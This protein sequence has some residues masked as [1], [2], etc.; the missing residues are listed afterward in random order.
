MDHEC[1]NVVHRLSLW[2]HQRVTARAY[3]L[4]RNGNCTEPG[5]RGVV[6]ALGDTN[7]RVAQ[8]QPS[9]SRHLDASE[10]RPAALT[11]L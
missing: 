8:L 6:P 11:E 4:G 5:I 1:R 7:G 3:A 2:S 9:G 10:V